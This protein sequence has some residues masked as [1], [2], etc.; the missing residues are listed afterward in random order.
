MS[1]LSDDKFTISEAVAI[2]K[3][4]LDGVVLQVELIVAGITDLVNAMGYVE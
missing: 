1:L 3:L 4:A 2:G